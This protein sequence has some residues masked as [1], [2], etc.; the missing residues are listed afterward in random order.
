MVKNVVAVTLDVLAA[1]AA[2]EV[3]SPAV[4]WTLGYPSPGT[5]C[6]YQSF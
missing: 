6:E 3:F 5:H 2:T 1:L 4:V